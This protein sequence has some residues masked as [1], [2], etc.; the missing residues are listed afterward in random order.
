[1]AVCGIHGFPNCA[2]KDKHIGI[3]CSF[4]IVNLGIAVN[5]VVSI[6]VDVWMDNR[7]MCIAGLVAVEIG[8]LKGNVKVA[9]GNMPTSVTAKS[10]CFD[11]K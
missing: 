7:V 4:N 1:L 2:E 11:R 9:M 8:T 5:S 6:A 3:P 10:S